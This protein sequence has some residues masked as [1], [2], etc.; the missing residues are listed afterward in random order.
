MAIKAWIPSPEMVDGDITMVMCWEFSITTL[1]CW[2]FP[3]SLMPINHEGDQQSP[4][5]RKGA[6]GFSVDGLARA[7][8]TEAH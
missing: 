5:K 8:L 2:E 7:S 1:M 3:I 6:P 4:R